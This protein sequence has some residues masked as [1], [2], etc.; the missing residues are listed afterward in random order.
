MK[1]LARSIFSR[2]LWLHVVALCAVAVVMPL[3]IYLLLSMNADLLEKRRL[4]A[5]AMAMTQMLDMSPQGRIRMRMDPVLK[6]LYERSFSGLAFAVVDEKGTILFAAP[7]QVNDVLASA[8]REMETTFFDLSEGPA[9]YYGISLPHRIDGK[10]VWIAITQNLESP[11]IIV[12]DV[13][14]GVLKRVSLLGL[15][16]FLILFVVDLI[17]VRRALSPVVEASRIAAGI[18]PKNLETRLPTDTLPREV[19]P[20]AAAVNDALTR[21]ERGYKLQ[22]DF[23][24]DVAHELRTPLAILRMHAATLPDGDASTSIR[25]GIEKMSRIIEQILHISELESERAVPTARVDLGEIAERVVGDMAPLAIARGQTLSLAGNGRPVTIAGN[26]ELLGIAIR[27]LVENA[28]L[29][30]PPGTN[31]EVLVEEAGRIIVC[32][33]GPGVGNEH[34]SHIFERFWRRDRKQGQGAG[35]GLSIVSKVAAMHDGSA[36]LEPSPSRGSRFALDLRNAHATA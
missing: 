29:H 32:D 34:R 18:D 19:L 9:V 14:A 4:N 13:I 21:L 10:W 33:D 23:S 35:L 2:I 6:S 3:A 27:N 24:S 20:L 26:G 31:I 11:D 12:D 16:L 25:R 22:R 7:Q 5:R 1:W 28:V 15:L 30:T 36:Y 17:I 8:P